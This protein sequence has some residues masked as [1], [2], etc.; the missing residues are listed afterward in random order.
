[1]SSTER[2]SDKEGSSSRRSRD[3][4]MARV[5]DT[6]LKRDTTSNNTRASASLR[7][8][9][10]ANWANCLEF[11]TWWSKRTTIG[12]SKDARSLGKFVG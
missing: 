12:D 11:F 5:V 3:T 7:L 6:H 10:V 2:Q 1:M 9:V 8:W 4:S